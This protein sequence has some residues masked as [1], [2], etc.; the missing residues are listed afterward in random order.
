MLTDYV[1]PTERAIACPNQDVVYGI[2]SL[3]LDQSA[4]V[5]QVPD[6]GS[7]FWVYQIVDLRMD[8]FAKLGAMYK[9]RPGFYLLVGPNWKGDVPKGITQVFRS[10]TNTG[11]VGPR[12]FMDDNAEDRKAVQEVLKSVMMY[13]LSEFDGKMKTTYWASLPRVPGASSGNK[14]MPWVIPDKFVDELPIVLQDA[15][16]MAGEQSQYA[17]ILAVVRAAQKDPG[18][19]M[20]MIKAA[21]ECETE[22]IHPLLQFR[23]PDRI[24]W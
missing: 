21:T 11:L 3:A 12:V 6:F 15:P 8:G 24:S 13:P 17:Q 22:V 10:K 7:R 23:W 18:I 1:I 5:I 9:S 2:G 19:K 4:V 14:E 20:A 16:P